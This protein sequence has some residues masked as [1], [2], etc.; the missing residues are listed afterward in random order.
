MVFIFGAG[1][2]LSKSSSSKCSFECELTTEK[3]TYPGYPGTFPV[4]KLRG[5]CHGNSLSP[6]GLATLPCHCPI[7]RE[8]LIHLPWILAFLS[9]CLAPIE[10]FRS[11]ATQ[12][13]GLGQKRLCKFYCVFWDICCPEALIWGTLFQTADAMLRSQSYMEKPH[14][15]VL[16]VSSR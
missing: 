9:D 7:K 6:R 12:L 5:S 4:L 3:P 10:C 16:V 2:I 13:V 14:V 11:D 15:G 1:Y 8:S